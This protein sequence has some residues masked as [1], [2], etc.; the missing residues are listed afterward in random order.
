MDPVVLVHGAWHGAWCWDGVVADLERRGVP[1]TAVE[2]PLSGYHADVETARGAIAGAGDG[3]VVVAHSYG[4]MVVSQA[5]AGLANVRRLVYIAAFQAE[6]G[7]DMVT[8]LS[9]HPSE[10]L[11]SLV[12]DERGVT[13]EPDRVHDIF[14]G[15]SDTTV[16][17]ACAA[18]L[19]P[20]SA[21]DPPVMTGEP[22]WRSIPSTYVVCQNDRAVP[23]EVQRQLAARAQEV[24]EWPTDHSPFLTRPGDIAVLLTA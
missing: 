7:E 17:A 22:A 16:A 5:A 4:G 23:P 21:E 18:R 2:L 9:Q 3:V 20:M 19:R 12:F 11:E 8:I 1:V 14:Y 15:D 6:D 13:V 24:V 10:L